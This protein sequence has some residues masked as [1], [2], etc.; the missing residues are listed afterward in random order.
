M[1]SRRAPEG[2]AM[3]GRAAVHIEV[4]S[5]ACPNGVALDNL[6]E[7]PRGSSTLVLGR[8]AP[9]HGPGK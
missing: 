5:S 8:Q 9:R 7:D 2:T 6:P 1:R 3:L 4:C